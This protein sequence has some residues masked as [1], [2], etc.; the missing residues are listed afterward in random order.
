MPH[1]VD[2]QREAVMEQPL[3]MHASADAG[4]V[5][6]V[7]GAL[8]QYAGPDAGEHVSGGLALDDQRV[9]AG[10]VQQLAEQQA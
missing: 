2:R 4:L 8:L 5:H 3:G 10:A 7:G 1:P 9:Y 6:Q